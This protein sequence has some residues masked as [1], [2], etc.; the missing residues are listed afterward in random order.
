MQRNDDGPSSCKV[1]AWLNGAVVTEDEEP[2]GTRSARSSRVEF[3]VA[4]RFEGAGARV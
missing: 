2:A 1:A 4:G 3:E